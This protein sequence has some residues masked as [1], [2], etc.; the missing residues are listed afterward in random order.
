MAIE[1]TFEPRY[2]AGQ[3]VT[4]DVASASV[5]LGFLSETMCL[6]NLGST[7]VYIRV[8]QAG[9]SASTADY[10]VF[11]SSQV[12]VS[13]SIDANT[14]AFISPGGPGSLHIIPGVGY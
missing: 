3:V 2:T 13:K 9:I 6:S 10:P 14:V 12:T 8:G 4:P 1:K 7:I 11:P 5:T